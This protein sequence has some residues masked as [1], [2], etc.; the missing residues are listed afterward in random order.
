LQQVMINLL[1]NAAQ[2]LEQVRSDRRRLLIQS[3]LDDAGNPTF[4][5]E[6]SGPGFDV[7]TADNLFIPFFT[8]KE[9]GMGMG[10]SI[11]RSIVEASGGRIAA[12]SNASG[13]ATFS[14]SLPDRAA[15]LAGQPRQS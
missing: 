15:L 4:A 7:K 9:S 6:D 11:C 1:L 8:T 2:A 3:F 12:R 13:G 10:L 14:V 5:I